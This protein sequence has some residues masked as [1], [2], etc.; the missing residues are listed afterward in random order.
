[1]R[2]ERALIT[3]ASSGLGKALCEKLNAHGI[4]LIITGRDR[5]KLEEL[6]RALG[7]HTIIESADL[8][9]AEERKKIVR[10]IHTYEPDLI[11]NNAG[12][13]LY[14]DA[15]SHST[16]DQLEIIEVNATAAFELTLEAARSLRKKN[17]TGTI[18]NISSAASFFIYPTFA[19]Y[20]AAKACV[21]SFSQALDAELSPLGIRVLTACPG[22]MNTPFRSRAAKGHPQKKTVG[23]MSIDQ[24]VSHLLWQI[25]KGK[26]LYIFDW[27]YKFLIFLGKYL[28]PTRLQEKLLI[29][30]LSKRSTSA[31]PDT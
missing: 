15:L 24:A 8:S 7:S 25:E 20:A 1:M 30:S 21:T 10:L 2:F 19:A 31:F 6:A 12:F 16:Q 27:R 5:H 14:G 18:L 4:S 28:V 11:I 9:N 3:G 13:G 26:R 29:R 17:R 23:T 22:Q